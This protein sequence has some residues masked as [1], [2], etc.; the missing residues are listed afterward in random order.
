MLAPSYVNSSLLASVAVKILSS[1]AQ[2]EF[3]SDRVAP[4]N[5][6]IDLVVR[7]FSLCDIR[8]MRDIIRFQ[9]RGIV[10]GFFGPPWSMTHR[11]ALFAFGA[12]R[13]MNTYLYA[14]K[15]D[16]YHRERW[17]TPYPAS[18]WRELLE[19]IRSARINKIDFVYGFHPGQALCFSEKEAVRVLLKKAQRFYAAGVRTF[20][21]LFDDIP[22]RLHY[23]VDRKAYDNSLA[24][25]ESM[26]MEKIIEHQ[27][28]TWKKVEWWFCP[29][30]YTPDPLLS[31]VFGAFEPDFLEVVAECLPDEIACLWTG[32]AVVPK[33]ITLAHVKS[34]AQ[35]LGHRLILWDNYPVNDL[36][37][38]DE[39][40]I[41]PLTG[42]DPLLPQSAYG[43]LNNPLLQENLSFLP[44]ATCFDYAADP[45]SYNGESSW[46][47][48]VKHRFG[49]TALPYWIA[50]RNFADLHQQSK[51][52]EPPLRL[53]NQDRDALRSAC[54]YIAKNRRK[55]WARE[56]EPWRGMIETALTQS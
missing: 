14:P 15:D 42:R 10:E 33:R 24:R 27:P 35:R 17:R 23:G 22:S 32:P 34:V 36:S 2:G 46:R 1:N 5:S 47:A 7:S 45:G 43:Y 29:S 6:L 18:R 16:P 52:S 48:A 3:K 9:R 40:H 25:A 56:I 31:R 54:D 37:M 49:A 50:L 44:L 21:V 8:A 38:R 28:A 13:G 20:A 41:G 53:R 11:K 51:Q 19:L 26:W 4:A 39:L 55:K 30:Y 12:P